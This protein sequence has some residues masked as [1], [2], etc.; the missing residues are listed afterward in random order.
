LKGKARSSRCHEERKKKEHRKK[1]QSGRFA[2]P[3][4][5]KTIYVQEKKNFLFQKEGGSVIKKKGDK[6]WPLKPRKKGVTF[7]LSR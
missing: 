6:S 4:Q 1:K 5:R 7:V 3:R 2:I